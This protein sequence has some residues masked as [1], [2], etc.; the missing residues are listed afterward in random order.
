MPRWPLRSP[1]TEDCRGDLT[2]DGMA[3][4]RRA[5]QAP[6]SSHFGAT[7]SGCISS[8]IGLFAAARPYQWN[9]ATAP[10][11]D[12][13]DGK[14]GGRPAVENPNSGSNG[15]ESGVAGLR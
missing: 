1:H 14:T 5:C 9:H 2:L 3:A 7:I 13:H 10:V 8:K 15:S 6:L 11:T 4:I 12:H